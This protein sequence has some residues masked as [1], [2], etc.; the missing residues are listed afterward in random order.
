VLRA[1]LTDDRF[2]PWFV[3]I[4]GN[5]PFGRAWFEENGSQTTNL[6]SVSLST[7]RRFPVPAISREEQRRLTTTYRAIRDVAEAASGVEARAVAARAALASSLLSGD[8]TIPD[9]YDRFLD[10]AA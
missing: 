4:W 7:L 9:S 6:A 3:S 1:R 2:D 10:G 8:T 5:S